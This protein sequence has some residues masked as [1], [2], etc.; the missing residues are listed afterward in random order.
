MYSRVVAFR[1]IPVTDAKVV[2]TVTSFLS[3]CFFLTQYSF[4]NNRLFLVVIANHSRNDLFG[5][6]HTC[7]INTS[8]GSVKTCYFPGQVLTT[9]ILFIFLILFILGLSNILKV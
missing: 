6:S 1:L 7:C 8:G 2:E 9:A 4:G 3:Y 5:L